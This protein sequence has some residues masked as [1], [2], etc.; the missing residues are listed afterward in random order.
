M[1]YITASQCWYFTLTE[2]LLERFFPKI[3][4]IGL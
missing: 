1:N 2:V 4:V 3:L